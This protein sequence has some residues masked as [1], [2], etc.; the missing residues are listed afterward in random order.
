MSEHHPQ[1][2]IFRLFTVITKRRLILLVDWYFFSYWDVGAVLG[3]NS[4]DTHFDSSAG[5][6]L[7]DYL[8]NIHGK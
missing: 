2:G 4:F 5:E 1:K 3:S 7:R 8:N 6:R